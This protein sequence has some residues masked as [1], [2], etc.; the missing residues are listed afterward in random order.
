MVSVV[1]LLVVHSF[2]IAEPTVFIVEPAV[3]TIEPVVVFAAEPVVE[4]IVLSTE[5]AAEPAAE[6]AAEPDYMALS[7]AVSKGRTVYSSS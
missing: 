6:L 2:P 3:P 4:P 1:Y 7:K 5:P